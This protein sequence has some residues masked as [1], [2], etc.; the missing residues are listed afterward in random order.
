VRCDHLVGNSGDHLVRILGDHQFGI[1][2]DHL[3]GI[4]LD[5]LHKVHRVG[6]VELAQV[7]HFSIDSATCT[8]IQF[9]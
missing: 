3:A 9:W 1:L 8:A 5:P 2:Y 6:I 4:L 7:I